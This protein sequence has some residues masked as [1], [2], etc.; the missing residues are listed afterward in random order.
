M[1]SKQSLIFYM[2]LCNVYRTHPPHTHTHTHTHTLI[3]ETSLGHQCVPGADDQDPAST[4]GKLLRQAPCH[5][6]WGGTDECQ[7][8][9]CRTGLM[10]PGSPPLLLRGS[11]LGLHSPSIQSFP[12]LKEG[13]EPRRKERTAPGEGG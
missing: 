6:A 2:C 9:T 5:K 7:S 13:R 8:K 3:N 4:P 10:A 1:F 11:S 12:E